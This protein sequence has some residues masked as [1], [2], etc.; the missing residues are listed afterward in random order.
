VGIS[1]PDPS[2][3]GVTVKIAFWALVF[4][5]CGAFVRVVTFQPAPFLGFAPRIETQILPNGLWLRLIAPK[6]QQFSQG[7]PM[8]FWLETPAG[9]Y[10]QNT[11]TKAG[12]T[13]AVFF[14]YRRAGEGLYSVK[15]AEFQAQGQFF[16]NSLAAVNPLQLHVGA[17]AVR[18]DTRRPPALVLHPVDINGNVSQEPITVT[19]Q[20]PD[21]Q[22]RQTQ[23]RSQHL[24]A[25]T[26]LPV[27]TK[28]GVLLVSAQTSRAFG[29][30]A[31]VDL[32]AGATRSGQ[33]KVQN[34]SSGNPSRDPVTLRLENVQDQFGNPATE[35]SA[36]EFISRSSLA[37]WNL[38]AIR[39]VV[40]SVASLRLP[41]QTTASASTAQAQN[42]GLRSP[43][44]PVILAFPLWRIWRSQGF[45]Y[46]NRI[47]DQIGATFDDGTAFEIEVQTKAEVLQFRAT[48]I[49]GRLVWK[50]PP[51]QAIVSI[52]VRLLGQE[53]VIIEK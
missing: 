8:R 32:L 39:P 21:G 28:T 24:V 37:G 27:G 47:F 25:W 13:Q 19:T 17:R 20:N 15:L 16:R 29:E 36:T 2:V 10:V 3:F 46:S 45:V 26:W 18:L 34:L 48:L 49:D 5:C 43:A 53:R 23:I 40:R 33:L 38:F 9:L 42:E 51:I 1:S 11:T 31:E 12:S 7:L 30:R 22:R 35:G 52:K 44:K 4:F 14:P 50:I 6:G 41:W